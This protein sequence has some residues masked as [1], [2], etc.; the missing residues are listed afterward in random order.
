M[1]RA[2]GDKVK[3]CDRAL[4]AFHPSDDLVR[5]PE[6]GQSD[7]LGSGYAAVL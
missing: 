2:T 4:H 7:Y 1:R 6:S 3:D 5:D